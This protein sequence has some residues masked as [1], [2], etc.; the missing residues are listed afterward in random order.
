MPPLFN[1]DQLKS[2]TTGYFEMK[3]LLLMVSQI[4]YYKCVLKIINCF[5]GVEKSVTVAQSNYISVTK[6]MV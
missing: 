1:F 2:Y 4:I 6:E 3:N 5:F